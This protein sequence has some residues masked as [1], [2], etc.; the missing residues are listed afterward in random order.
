MRRF[1]HDRVAH[2][3][4]GDDDAAPDDRRNGRLLAV[5][6]RDPDGIQHR[7]DKRQK[8][9]LGAFDLAQA[10]GEEEVGK[11]ELDGSHDDEQR[12]VLGVNVALEQS[13]GEEEGDA[14]A[15]RERDRDRVGVAVMAVDPGLPGGWLHEA[16]DDAHGGGFAGAVRSQKSHHL[17]AADGK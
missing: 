6:E 8:A 16:A 10:A 2:G 15:V 13:E 11:R 17:A 12:Q 3:K 14:H 5:E 1:A 4:T 7:F 9:R